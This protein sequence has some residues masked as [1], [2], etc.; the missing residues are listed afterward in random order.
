[1]NFTI[2][3]RTHNGSLVYRA[4]AMDYRSAFMVADAFW[5]SGHAEACVVL[6]NQLVRYS[7][8]QPGVELDNFWR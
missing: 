6:E 5:K 1:M 3:W 8:A 2:V 4:W 7:W